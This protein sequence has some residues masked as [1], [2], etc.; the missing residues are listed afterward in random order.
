MLLTINF[1]RYIAFSVTRANN[2]SHT[3]SRCLPGYNSCCRTAVIKTTYS[4]SGVNLK[5]KRIISRSK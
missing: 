3:R 2:N 5:R 1:K 4:H